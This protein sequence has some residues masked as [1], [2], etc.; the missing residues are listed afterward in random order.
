M[1]IA[2]EIDR[3]LRVGR[4]LHVHA[5]KVADGDGM[6]Q[7]F[8]HGPVGEGLVDVKAEVGELEADVGVQPA[9]RD[10]IQKLVIAGFAAQRLVAIGYVFAEVVHRD[11]YARPVHLRG[12]GDQLGQRATGDVAP[13]N[14][15]PNCGAL[16]DRTKNPAGGESNQNGAQHP[17]LPSVRCCISEKR[18]RRGAWGAMH[19]TFALK[20]ATQMWATSACTR[21]SALPPPDASPPPWPPCSLCQM[22]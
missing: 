21:L 9:P 6:L 10:L 8:F 1:Q 20:N 11:V 13:R 22:R 3:A 19:P 4:T 5:D 2:H 18:T 16:G 12:G 15:L 14:S 7:Q 17:S